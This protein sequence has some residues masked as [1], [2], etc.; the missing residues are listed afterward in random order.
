M[1]I[2]VLFFYINIDIVFISFVFLLQPASYPILLTCLHSTQHSLKAVGLLG[3]S[4]PTSSQV[5]Q[6]A[7]V[8]I[9]VHYHAAGFT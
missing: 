8:T 1:R 9:T 6:K 2:S 4:V 7:F 3:L 5:I